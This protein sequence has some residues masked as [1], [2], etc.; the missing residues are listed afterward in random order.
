MLGIE[1]SPEAF[2]LLRTSWLEL[3]FTRICTVGYTY[4]AAICGVDIVDEVVA[5][6]MLIWC[7]RVNRMAI[8]FQR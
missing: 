5:K 8:F 7:P 6:V 2:M 4:S 1:G 3:V